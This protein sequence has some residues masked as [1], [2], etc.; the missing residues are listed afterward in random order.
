MWTSHHDRRWRNNHNLCNMDR[1]RV[2]FRPSIRREVHIP[3]T[4]A[5][6]SVICLLPCEVHLIKAK[7]KV[8]RGL[9]SGLLFGTFRDY[10]WFLCFPLT[11]VGWPIF[12]QKSPRPLTKFATAHE[13]NKIRSSCVVFVTA[14]SKLCDIPYII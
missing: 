11:L 2:R 12:D 5:P 1:G 3:R 13:K 14:K 6:R 8:K 7:V 9:S 4:S 10:G